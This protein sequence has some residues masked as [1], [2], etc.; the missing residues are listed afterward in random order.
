MTVDLTHDGLVAVVTLDR[1]ERRN[2]VDHSTLLELLD[3]Q[4]A[5]SVRSPDAIRAVVLTGAPPAF[6]AG[7]DL[8]G[9]EEGQF[10]VDL[11]AVL[12]GFG[13][14]PVPVIAAIDGPRWGWRSAGH[15]HRPPGRHR[16]PA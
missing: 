1:P 11:A 8:N 3:I 10:N 13:E 7:A 2:A 12:R 16:P 14:P 15:R 9:V 6:S 5:I 4:A